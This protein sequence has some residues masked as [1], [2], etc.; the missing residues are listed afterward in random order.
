VNDP[1]E[2]ADEVA[3]LLSDAATASRL[4]DAGRDILERNRGALA[5]LMAMIEPLLD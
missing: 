2:L 3:R 4:G 5:R 1:T